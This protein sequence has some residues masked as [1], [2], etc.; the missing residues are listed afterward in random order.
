MVT[1][2]K[3]PTSRFSYP[4]FLDLHEISVLVVGGGRIG[5]R[6]AA[7]LLASG[8][9]VRLVAAE[10]SEHVDRE[11]VGREVAAPYEPGLPGQILPLLL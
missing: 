11:L 7:G 9:V 2:N 5:W 10:V 1:S 6:K 3:M 4:V 8:A